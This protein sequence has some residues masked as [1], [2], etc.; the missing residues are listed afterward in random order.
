M[1]L[2]IALVVLVLAALGFA[3]LRPKADVGGSEARRIV[4]AGGRLVDVRTPQ[5]FASGHLP[6]AVNVPV[7][8]LE[9]RLGELDPKDAPLVVYCRSGSRS[10]RAR[11]IL[12]GAGFRAVHDLGAQTNW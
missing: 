1:A 4:E 7:Q 12:Q 10:A 11:S 8:D 5:E 2:K 3:F 6:G 9:R